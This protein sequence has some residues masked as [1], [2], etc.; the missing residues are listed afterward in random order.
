M[1]NFANVMGRL[2]NVTESENC[3]RVFSSTGG[4]K[5]LDFYS[6]IGGMRD[7]S[8][9]DIIVLYREARVEDPILADNCVLYARDIRQKG[10][11]ERRIGRLLLHELA[12]I[13]PDKVIRNL[14]KIVKAGRWDD[15]W[16]LL[17]TPVRQAVLEV[18]KDQ[19]SSDIEDMKSEKAISLISKWLPSPNTS[20]SETRAIAR[21]I[22]KG[23]NISER[24]YRKT[25]SRLRKYIGIL[26]R[27]MSDN[28]WTTI[29][30]SKVPSIAMHRYIGAF[31]RRLPEQFAKY[32]V[33]LENGKTKVN[34]SVIT[35]TE[36]CKKWIT[37][38]PTRYWEISPKTGILDTVDLAQWDA[39]PNYVNGSYDVVVMCDISGSMQAP[40]Y[41]PLATS[42]GLSTY[43]AQRNKGAYHGKYLTFSTNPKFVDI[44]G[45]STEKAFCR[46]LNEEA[47]YSTNM[48]AAFAAIYEVAKET[49]EVPKAIVVV[50]D[51]ELDS[52]VQNSAS[53]SIVSKW[54]NKFKEL[55]L[56]PVKVVSWNVADRHNTKL[57]PASDYISYCS[58]CAPATFAH[59]DTLIREDAYTAMYRILTLPQFCWD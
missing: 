1:S 23:V 44:S 4:G 3:G 22:C 6:S 33:D 29:D 10:L 17:D 45:L 16:V 53:D 49:H 39:M 35:P 13:D 14:N 2:S 52:W 40:D 38:C 7:R 30:F 47:G 43:F 58:G 54:N 36:I 31:N 41:E 51:G 32:K 24:S 57:A 9:R 55:G 27:T 18:I 48:D 20:S 21:D 34:A 25:L 50:S 12:T 28:E 42:I 26:E 5:V 46:A 11:G 19:L 8:D 37:H 59:L 15:L 56:E